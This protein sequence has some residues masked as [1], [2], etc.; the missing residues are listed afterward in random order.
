M[1]KCDLARQLHQQG[2]NCAQSVLIASEQYTELDPGIAQKVACGFG[3]GVRCGEICGCVTGGVMALGCRFPQAEMADITKEYVS[4]FRE[5]HGCVRCSEL[6]EQYGGK[7]K[8]EDMMAF[9][10]SL[11]SRVFEAHDV[12]PFKQE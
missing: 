2:Y 11:T 7:G 8:C 3:G 5:A 9:G 10:V 6:I 1:N 12:H 4:A